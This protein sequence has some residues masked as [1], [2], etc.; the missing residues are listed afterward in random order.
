MRSGRFRGLADH[1]ES[2]RTCRRPSEIYWPYNVE[3]IQSELG[4]FLLSLTRPLKD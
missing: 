1:V 2:S 3:I 4:T